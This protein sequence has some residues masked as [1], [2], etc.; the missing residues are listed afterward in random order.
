[1]NSDQFKGGL[2]EVSGKF[3]ESTGKIINNESMKNDGRLD[4]AKGNVQRN[5]GNAKEDIK[6]AIDKV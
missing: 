5:Y 3:K 1:M 4:Q 2:R 6:D